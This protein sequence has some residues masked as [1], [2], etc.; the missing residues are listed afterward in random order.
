MSGERLHGGD[1]PQQISED[2]ATLHD[3]VRRARMRSTS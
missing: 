1:G 2:L 3:S